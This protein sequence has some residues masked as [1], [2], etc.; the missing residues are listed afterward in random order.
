MRK[1]LIITLSFLGVVLL[2]LD[3]LVYKELNQEGAAFLVAVVV[4]ILIITDQLFLKHKFKTISMIL[5]LGVIFSSFFCWFYLW[6]VWFGYGYTGRAESWNLV[7]I[8][9]TAIILFVVIVVDKTKSK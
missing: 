4:L 9:L 7:L 3:L 1:K 2:L 5:Y 8:Y 6:L